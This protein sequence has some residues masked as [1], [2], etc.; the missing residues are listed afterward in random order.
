MSTEPKERARQAIAWAGWNGIPVIETDSSELLER[1]LLGG[2]SKHAVFTFTKFG[3]DD[4]VLYENG[5]KLGDY[6]DPQV[7]DPIR[8][9]L[10]GKPPRVALEVVSPLPPPV[11]V[12]E[13]SPEYTAE[14]VLR[15]RFSSIE[16][17]SLLLAA[18]ETGRVWI[19][20]AP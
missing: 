1:V 2:S 10:T 13:A 8:A 17:A 15:G 3:I 6:H 19:E 16:D 20:R 9:F 4:V 7:L 12:N 18:L 14:V 5:R 11:T